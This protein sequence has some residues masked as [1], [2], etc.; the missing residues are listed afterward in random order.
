MTDQRNSASSSHRE[1]TRS[2]FSAR[3]VVLMASVVTGL[4]AYGF[5][6]SSDRFDIFGSA[7]QAQVANAAS[8]AAQP[9]GFADVVERVKPSVISVKVTMKKATDASDKDDADESGSPMERFF[10]QFGGPNDEFQNPNVVV[11]R[12]IW[13][14]GRSIAFR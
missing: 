3:K 9:S 2:L 6:S 4:A 12:M 14:A 1:Q 7:A 11:G 5:S 10:R 8:S 13:D